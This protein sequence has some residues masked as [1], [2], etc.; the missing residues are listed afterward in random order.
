MYVLPNYQNTYAGGGNA[1]LQQYVWK[2]GQPEAWKA[3]DGKYYHNYSDDA[4]WGP[5]MV[6]QEYIPWYAWYE[7]T[8]YSFK[9]AKLNPQPDN[10][11][12]YFQTASIY[13]NSISFSKATDNMNLRVSYG[14]VDVKGLLPSSWLKKHTLNINTSVDLNQHF[15]LSANVNYIS[16]KRQG[17]FDDGYSNQSTGSFNQWFHRD[18]DMGIMKE[19]RGLRTPT[20]IYASWNHNDP[21]S[22]KADDPAAF[23]AG[24]YWYNFYTWADLVRNNDGLDRL[25]GDISLTYKINNDLRVRGT[26]RK[27]QNTTWGESKYSSNLATSGTQTTGNCGECKGFYSTG[28]SYSNRE[29]LEVMATYTKKVNDFQFGVNAGIDFFR[30]LFK[31]NSA[32]TVDGLNVPDLFNINNSKGRPVIGNGR[33]E[34]KYKAILVKGDIGWRNLLFADFTLRNDWYSTLPPAN[35]DVLSKSFGIS[36]VFSDLLKVPALSYGKIRASWGEIP[37]HWEQPL[38]PLEHTVIQALSL[39]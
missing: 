18:L 31:S 13:N 4:S 32:Q 22:Y 29:N 15:T 3:L 27:Q 12:D 8:P 35:N 26:Y 39:V 21:T 7:G 17:D 6:G 23:Y 25:Y 2:P 36:F 28:E 34:E 33:T 38:Q 9:T 24:N 30:W 1:D 14:N 5:R 37:K 11:K 19:L 10:G 16:Q 20:G